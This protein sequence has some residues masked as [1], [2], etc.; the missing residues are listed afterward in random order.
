MSYKKYNQDY[1]KPDSKIISLD[2]KIKTV[3]PDDF[4]NKVKFLCREIYDVEWSGILFYSIEGSIK[5]P[6]ELIITL[7][8]ILP[9][10]KGSKAYTEYELDDRFVNFMMDNP[11]YLNYEIGH[12][13]SH[14]SMNVFFSGTDDSELR[15][16]SQNHRFYLSLIVNNFMDFKAKVATIGHAKSSENIKLPY[17]AEDEDGESY[18]VKD[19]SFKVDSKKM[20]VYDCE[21]ISK[22]EHISV[23]EQF[24][25]A[26]KGLFKTEKKKSKT[27]SVSNQLKKKGLGDE[28]KGF[29][30]AKD[31]VKVY[32]EKDF[33][34][35]DEMELFTMAL[36]NLSND[37]KKE[38]ELDTVF[39]M[40]HEF[41]ITA[42]ELAKSTIHV[43]V[44]I[45]AEF[46]PDKDEK[47]FIK[48]GYA[49]I[50]HIEQYEEIFPILTM[51]KD[52]ISQMLKQYEKQ[53]ENY[54]NR[55]TI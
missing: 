47:E 29:D 4:L 23:S 37:P 26:V 31:F 45:Y 35:L 2:T 27:V 8:D 49:V 20:F 48:D 5:N 33:Q 53:L 17:M 9:M 25:T 24:M 32:T 38:D 54:E 11:D 34:D 55:V 10:D 16:N 42:H 15:D 18:E 7:K 50:E 1:L 40:L 3:M 46:F 13:H 28:K 22:Q 21:I 19:G 6:E 39:E 14:N 41:D 51:S 12:I 44:E 52:A 43:Y 36:F 30:I